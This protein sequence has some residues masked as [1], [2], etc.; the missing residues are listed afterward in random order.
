LD[1]FVATVSRVLMK[2]PSRVHRP[3]STV[4]ALDYMLNPIKTNTHSIIHTI[5]NELITIEMLQIE[6][7][8]L[9]EK[10]EKTKRNGKINRSLWRFCTLSLSRCM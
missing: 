9:S 2:V 6:I 3:H 10:K 8:F 1:E 5:F 4:S 7:I